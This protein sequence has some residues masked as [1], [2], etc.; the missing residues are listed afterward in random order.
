MWTGVHR[1]SRQGA[2]ADPVEALKPDRWFTK[3]VRRVNV[4]SVGEKIEGVP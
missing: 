1:E 4:I 3:R 2:N